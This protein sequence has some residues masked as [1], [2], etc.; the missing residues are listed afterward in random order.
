MDCVTET[1]MCVPWT[2]FIN[3]EIKY[4]VAERKLYYKLWNNDRIQELYVIYSF[5]NLWIMKYITIQ[6]NRNS[7]T[8]SGN[9]MLNNKRSNLPCT[10][11]II[12]DMYNK[13]YQN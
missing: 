13:I 2:K 11:V 4:S 10:K 8:N 3:I 7:N 9:V 12:V 5:G 6:Q 1:S